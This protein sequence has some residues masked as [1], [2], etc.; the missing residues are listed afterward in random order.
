MLPPH[1]QHIGKN[2]VL[3]TIFKSHVIVCIADKLFIQIHF[4][5]ILSVISAHTSLQKSEVFIFHNLCAKN[6]IFFT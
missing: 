1:V 5:Q 4:M 6:V 2:P 3:K